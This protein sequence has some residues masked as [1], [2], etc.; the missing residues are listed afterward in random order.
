M[1]LLYMNCALL[2]HKYKYT[3]NRSCS[4]MGDETG[5]RPADAP[6]R[7]DTCTTGIWSNPHASWFERG[8]QAKVSHSRRLTQLSSPNNQP[9]FFF[10]YCILLIEYSLSQ[11]SQVER[12]D[13]GFWLHWS[14]HID[15]WDCLFYLSVSPL[16]V[17]PDA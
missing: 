10:Y 9:N 5:Q 15:S 12:H 4:E 8:G 6:V 1:I 2:H 17:L 16:F 7:K 13:C 3:N 14:I 11:T